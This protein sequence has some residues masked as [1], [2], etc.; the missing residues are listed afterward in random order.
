MCVTRVLNSPGNTKQNNSRVRRKE[1]RNRKILAIGMVLVLLMNLIGV[2]PIAAQG[3][4]VNAEPIDVTA[5]LNKLGIGDVK[6]EPMELPELGRLPSG[7]F[8]VGDSVYALVY[9]DY[10][11]ALS[12]EPF[13]VF[14]VTDIVEVWVAD[15]LSYPEG[16]PRNPV[17]VTQEQAE[18][19]AQEFTDNIYP[20]DTEFFGMPNEHD[21]T[22]AILPGILG[23]PDDYYV[24]T[25]NIIMITNVQDDQYY[26]PSYPFYIAGFYW[27]LYEDYFDRN[28]INIDS[29]DW[30]NRL[31]PDD[32][33]WRGPDPDLWRPNLYEGTVAHEYQHLIHDDND[34]D[35]ETWVNE[36]MSMFAEWLCGYEDFSH[37]EY[38]VDHAENSLVMWGDQ[39]DSSTNVS[40][41]LSDYGIVYLWTL[42][43]YEHF[44]GGPFVQAL[45]KS[46]TNGISGVNETLAEFGY[47]ATFIDVFHDFRIACLIDSPRAFKLPFFPW[48]MFGRGGD[49]VHP[50]EFRNI[51][52]NVNVD[53]FEAWGESGAPPWGTD[54]IKVEDESYF[55]MIKFD[56]AD[57]VGMWP[58]SGDY[59]WYSTSGTALWNRLTQTFDI[60]A[61]GAT[62][63]FWIGYDTEE[64]WD[65]AYVMV[66]DLAADTWA[67][68]PGLN[69]TDFLY[70]PQDIQ[71]DPW[72]DP[73]DF[74]QRDEDT[75]LCTGPW[76]GFTGNSDGYLA[77]TMDLSPFAG[78]TIELS[79]VYW[80]DNYV[81][82]PGAYIDDVSIPE[83]GFSDDMET[84]GAWVNNGWEHTTGLVE[85]DFSVTLVGMYERFGK[86]HY[87]VRDMYLDDLT[88]EGAGFLAGIVRLGGHAVLMVTFDAE[89]G[90]LEYA[91]YE[92]VI[93]YPWE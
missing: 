68:L 20:T 77:E 32:A 56:G 59:Q 12:V 39:E 73:E 41:I 17:V 38:F 45:A 6:L 66:H 93:E 53:T 85:A 46:E 42:Y 55:K 88:E 89:E 90:V 65:Y 71:A 19:M 44:G 16:D 13:T 37:I 69:T 11:G 70:Y 34:S 81:A 31:G 86:T 48:S 15:D 63:N 14:A 52:V 25:K 80:T 74:C 78:H 33:P 57:A 21:G 54:Y 87:I 8:E 29:R 91:P 18:Y 58:H 84:E 9:D 24:G 67:T 27:G 7:D 5:R 30:A 3:P 76:Y 4:V 49:W 60:P 23:L 83:I 61:T 10:Y 64:D 51:D 26:D 28:I 2:A 43:L 1:M 47:D 50:Y 36:G 79:F 75:L 40:E 62:L 22:N 82:F 35:E 72:A 92:Y